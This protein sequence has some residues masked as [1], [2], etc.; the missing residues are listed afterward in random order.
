MI[1]D[2]LRELR[3]RRG[4]SL[5]ALAA[6]AGVSATLL[7]QIERGVTEPSLAT[8][9]R[10][11]NVFGESMATLFEDGAAPSVWISRPGE[12]ST[13]R[14]PRGQ[15]GYERLTPGNGQ[16]E[17]LRGVLEPG[18]AISSEPWSHVALE[19]AFVLAGTLTVELD[20]KPNAV[21]AGEAIT[22]DSR[23]AHRYLNC[24]AERAE[25]LLS[26]APPTP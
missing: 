12:R 8:L 4:L 14:G 22:F 21:H 11:A 16:M 17:V 3:T 9:R 10:L 7:S 26:V 2:Q 20:G 1:G 18:E 24:G 25:F 6:D 15:I 13:L 23:L 5:R 19:C